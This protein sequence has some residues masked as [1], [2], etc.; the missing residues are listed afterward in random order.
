M[1][2]TNGAICSNQEDVLKTISNPIIKKFPP[3]VVMW[4]KVYGNQNRWKEVLTITAE[5]DEDTEKEVLAAVGRLNK[6]LLY[7][8]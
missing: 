2:L 6:I 7:E 8:Y 4:N 5:Y 3:I 1:K